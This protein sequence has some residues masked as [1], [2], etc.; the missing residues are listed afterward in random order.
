MKQTVRLSTIQEVWESWTG[1]YWFATE[2][3]DAGICFGLV[4]GFEEEWGY[5][6]IRELVRLQNR[7]GK[8]WRVPR[9]HWIFCPC[10]VDDTDHDHLKGGED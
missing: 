3:Y 10:V 7:S 1:W 5:F 8:V 6:S 2:Y 9:D 4:R